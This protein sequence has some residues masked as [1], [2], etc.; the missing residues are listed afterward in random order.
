MAGNTVAQT[1][2]VKYYKAHWLAREVPERQAR[3]KKVTT[4]YNDGRSEV[5]VLNLKKDCLYHTAYYLNN[6]PTGIWSRYTKKCELI[7]NWDYSKLVFSAQR[8]DTLF[9][10]DS[11]RA[12]YTVAN[13]GESETD[14]FKYIAENIIY[15]VEA[16]E[17]GVTGK[18]YLQVIVHVTGELEVVSILNDVH[19]FLAIEAWELIAGMPNWNPATKNGLP[20][21]SVMILPINFVLQDVY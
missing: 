11:K 4:T 10:N 9:D 13:Y 3:F 5:E 8:I 14:A 19:P 16:R 15:P 2:S 17:N 1:T 7:R 18:V 21:K 20:I 12:G 6:Q